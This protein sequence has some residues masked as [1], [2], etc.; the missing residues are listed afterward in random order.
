[1]GTYKL[2]LKQKGKPDEIRTGLDKLNSVI[3]PAELKMA[4]PK[5]FENGTMSVEV[6]EEK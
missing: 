5:Q 6:V 1:M 2:T 4:F 3:I